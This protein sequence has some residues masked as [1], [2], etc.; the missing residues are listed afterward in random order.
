MMRRQAT[1][2]PGFVFLFLILQAL[3]AGGASA[4]RP[5]PPPHGP[6]GP[7]GPGHPPPLEHVLERHAD[8]LGL[9][10]ETRAEIDRLVSAA[11]PESDALRDQLRALQDEMRALLSRDVPD[12]EAVMTQAER[13]GDV[14]TAMQ[15]KQLRSMLRIRALLTPEQRAE[16]VRIHEERELGGRHERRGP[17]PRSDPPR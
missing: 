2:R 5:G 15:K 12:E 1:W 14:E 6:G 7:R 9:D 10:A 8:R 4:Q 13:I 3:I 16:L 17:R 11:R